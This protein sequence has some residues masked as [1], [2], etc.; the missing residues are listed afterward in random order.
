MTTA[1]AYDWTV[2]GLPFMAAYTPEMPYERALA[3][4]VKEQVDSS[5][6][7]GD[8]SLDGWWVRSQTDWMAGAGYEW[9]EPIGEEPI[10][11]TFNWSYGVNPWHEG[12]IYLHRTST[13]A[14]SL[15]VGTEVQHMTYNNGRIYFT[16]KDSN[17]LYE[18]PYDNLSAVT[19]LNAPSEIRSIVAAFGQLLIACKDGGIYSIAGTVA[20]KIYDTPAEPR[21]WFVKNRLIIAVGGE[22]WVKPA[23]PTTLP[24]SLAPADAVVKYIDRGWE[25][26]DAT[27]GLS[28]IYMSG[29]GYDTQGIFALTIDATGAIPVMEA[30]IQVAVMPV[31]E[32]VLNI[33]SY[34][35]TYMLIRTSSGVRVGT[36]SGDVGS[37]TFG[38]L[39]KCGTVRGPFAFWDRFAYSTV[40]DAGE[41]RSGLIRFDLSGLTQQQT[42]PWALDV[43]VPTGDPNPVT[44]VMVLGQDHLV[45]GGAHLYETKPTSAFESY[46]VLQSGWIRMGTTVEKTWARLGLTRSNNSVGR[47]SGY[48]VTDDGTAHLAGTIAAPD[49]KK[50]FSLAGLG[51]KG[52]RAAVRIMLH[53]DS[54]PPVTTPPVTPPLPGDPDYPSHPPGATDRSWADVAAAGTWQYHIDLANTWR[55]FGATDGTHVQTRRAALPGDLKAQ[56]PSFLSLPTGTTDLEAWSLRALPAVPRQELVRVPLLCFDWELDGDGNQ[57]G[58]VGTAITRYEELLD[59]VDD[60]AAV[61]LHDLNN[62]RTYVVSV[63]DMSFRQ[64]AAPDR[65]EGF[66]GVID[67]TGSIL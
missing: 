47:V 61:T 26:T 64:T 42:V 7:P 37:L 57:I 15:P 29:G 8:Q 23:L 60:G 17:V 33:D 44:Q 12:E 2:A 11:S 40:A 36:L 41:G 3:R 19:T 21:M 27:D 16:S 66:G 45:F 28:A 67:L 63:S 56:Q 18:A 34:M 9:M 46:G 24:G 10:P 53:A 48:I 43:R 5:N 35:G 20:T 4:V 59:A 25:W 49:F 62:D 31:Q 55:T 51:L 6:E 52:T 50:S 54:L 39:M 32:K 1:A 22:L 38:P 14:L 65:A 58:G 13:Q 30:P